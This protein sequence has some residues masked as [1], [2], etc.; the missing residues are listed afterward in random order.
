MILTCVADTPSAVAPP[1]SP[2]DHCAHGGMYF[3]IPIWR[4][5][6]RQLGPWPKVTDDPAPPA[7]P[8]AAVAAPPV[9]VAV[10]PLP[11]AVPDLPVDP[12]ADALPARPPDD[13]PPVATW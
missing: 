1:L 7:A 9:A 8:P 3:E 13:P 10:A 6:G 4:P 12:A 2:P 5:S 11:A